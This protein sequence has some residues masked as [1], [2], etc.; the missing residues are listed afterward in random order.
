MTALIKNAAP[1]NQGGVFLCTNCSVSVI[2]KAPFWG[3][4]QSSSEE[5]IVA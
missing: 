4:W 1:S 3:L 2:A 5:Q